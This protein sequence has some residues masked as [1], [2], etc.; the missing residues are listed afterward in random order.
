[1]RFEPR[2]SRES[3]MKIAEFPEV[4]MLFEHI[5]ENLIEAN[6]EGIFN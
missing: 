4:R 5:L 3:G 2:G 6:Q 1:M